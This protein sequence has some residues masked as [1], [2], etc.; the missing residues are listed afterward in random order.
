MCNMLIDSFVEVL[1]AEKG[2]SVH[3]CRAYGHDIKEFF[4]FLFPGIDVN[5]VSENMF[6]NKINRRKSN[7]V[8]QYMVFLAKKG[9]GK[10]YVSRKLSSLKSFFGYC[11]KC[12][13]IGVNP[14]NCVP[15]PKIGV[16]IPEFLSVDDVFMLLDSI[17]CDTLFDKRNLAMFELF[18][19]TGMRVSELVNLDMDHIDFAKNMIMIS[20]KGSKQRVVPVGKRALNAIRQY[21]SALVQVYRPVFLNKNRTRLSDRSVRRILTH[22]VS[23]CGLNVPVS[24]HTL[25]HCF[26]THMLDS[27][28]DLRGIQEILGHSSLSTTQVYTHVST[29]HLM[30]VYDRAHPRS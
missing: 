28:A 22:I 27:G 13:K 16:S 19:S 12:G 11:I 9:V 14:A 23:M 3:T 2:Y 26:A 1:I 25:R 7:V 24:P 17:Q 30:E 21:R 6:I 4:K 20:G 15:S 5:S 10:R 8:R 29:G 18:Y